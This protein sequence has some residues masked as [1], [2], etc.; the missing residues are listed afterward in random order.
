MS[1][2]VSIS[3]RPCLS[4]CASACAYPICAQA[5]VSLRPA[6]AHRSYFGFRLK[7]PT[8]RRRRF[9]RPPAQIT[10]R[11]QPALRAPGLLCGID[12]GAG[13]RPRGR[14]EAGRVRWGTPALTLLGAQRASAVALAT[15]GNVTDRQ[16]VSSLLT[17]CPGEAI[18][19]GRGRIPGPAGRG[20]PRVLMVDAFGL[21]LQEALARAD[22]VP[23]APT[24]H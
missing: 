1:L 9:R 6:P 17:S 19:V 18:D 13:V 24:E 14:K 2:S 11:T 15:G 21:V 7:G 23:A 22:M 5:G 16:C 3:T 12:P 8:A 20:S 4:P 10:R